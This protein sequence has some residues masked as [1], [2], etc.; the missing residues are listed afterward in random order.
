MKIQHLFA[1]LLI[2]LAS[3]ALADPAQYYGG[4][5]PM[6]IVCPDGTT[7]CFASS[8]NGASATAPGT[9]GTTAQS[10]QG[11]PGGVAVPIAGT[12]GT[13]TPVTI[14]ATGFYIAAS[15][16]GSTGT[17]VAPVRPTRK[18]IQILNVGAGFCTAVP[19]ASPTSVAVVIDSGTT[20]GNGYPLEAASAAGH[21][22]GSTPIY[23]G[24]NT[25]DDAWDVLCT[26]PSFIRVLEGN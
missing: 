14:T 4:P 22:G 11:I 3:P 10:V 20:P 21:Q 18:S 25:D 12:I 5:P 26:S 23:D 15:T 8:G 19:T 1:P 16:S 7:N 24:V 9:P 13:N 2:S 17:R 6:R